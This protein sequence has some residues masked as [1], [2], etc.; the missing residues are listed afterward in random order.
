[1]AH[2]MRGVGFADRVGTHALPQ[3]VVQKRIVVEQN[4]IM[5]LLRPIAFLVHFG[6]TF[7]KTVLVLAHFSTRKVLSAHGLFKDYLYLRVGI[8]LIVK[9]FQLVVCHTTA[10]L[11]K[12]I[13]PSLQ[14]IHHALKGRNFYVC[15]LAQL[16]YVAAKLF[17]LDVH[18]LVGSPS[19]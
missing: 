1:M 17:L 5:I 4:T 18:G 13:V 6:R 15:R 8:F 10:V 12:E 7:Q 19:G 2:G 16:F 3:S 14:G 11:R 9:L